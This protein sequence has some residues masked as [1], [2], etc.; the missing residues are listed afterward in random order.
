M[1]GNRAIRKTM[2]SQTDR[3]T[4]EG[5]RGYKRDGDRYSHKSDSDFSRETTRQGWYCPS[6]G[7]ERWSRL[8]YETTTDHHAVWYE[9]DEGRDL[10]E[11]EGGQSLQGAA[12]PIQTGLV[13]RGSWSPGKAVSEGTGGQTQREESLL[14][15]RVC[16]YRR[17]KSGGTFHR[18]KCHH[19][20]SESL[21]KGTVTVNVK[22]E[23]Y[24]RLFI[25]AF[26]PIFQA[27][28][29]V[30]ILFHLYVYCF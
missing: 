10:E 16:Y 18:L 6:S 26:N 4:G 8:Q 23:I 20:D 21:I 9:D 13:K 28:L 14:E 27:H 29:R 30:C 25:P 2:E 19:L 15:G 17:K 12:C 1:P 5:K 11:V 3:A 24:D 7:K 22:V